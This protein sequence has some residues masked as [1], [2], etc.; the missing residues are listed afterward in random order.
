MSIESEELQWMEEEQAA[1]GPEP[2][3]EEMGYGE[4]EVNVGMAERIGSVIGGAAML[5]GGVY[6]AAKRRPI[7][8]AIMGLAGGLLLQRGITGHCPAYKAMNIDTSEIGVPRMGRAI[9][10]EESVIIN[11]PAEELYAFWRDFKNLPR[12][13][14]HLERVDV[15]DSRKSRWVAE[16]PGGQL[17]EWEAEITHE[18][19]NEL[20]AWATTENAA[21]PNRGS[22]RFRRASG[23]RGTIVEVMLEY[24]PPAGALGA[25]IAKL[26]GREPGREIRDDLLAFKARMEAGEV[27]TVEGQPRGTCGAGL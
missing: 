20:I 14:R 16:G 12:V 8:S 5:G 13:M 10:V 3:Y 2:S 7:G 26:L 4:A 18:R 17:I 9:S 21:V 19:P 27:P 22:V 23:N 6:F 24:R 25:S 11:R 15:V 1:A